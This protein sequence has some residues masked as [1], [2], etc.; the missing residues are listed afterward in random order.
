M[1]LALKQALLAARISSFLLLLLW[2]LL[3]SYDVAESFAAAAAA[4]AA[5]A[6]AAT[7]AAATA[8]A[9]AVVA[10]ESFAVIVSPEP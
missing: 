2:L 9:V 10:V 5:A 6:T 4:A 7:A 1:K 3:G 8:A